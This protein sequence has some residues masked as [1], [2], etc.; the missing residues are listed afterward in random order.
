MSPGAQWNL[1]RVAGALLGVGVA[2]TLLVVS[3][4]GAA[5]APVPASVRFALAPVGE[6]EVTPAPPR[7]AL[8]ARGLRPG[9]PRASGYFELR[10]QTGE[11]LSVRLKAATDSSSLDGLLKVEVRAGDR[12]LTDTTLQGLGLHPPELRLASGE[13]ARLRLAAW[14]PADV[15][16][17]YEGARVEVTL[18]P[19]PRSVGVPR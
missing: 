18:V 1:V 15:L 9:G 17:G 4:P 8:V 10:N 7:P 19:A 3:R 14:L 12:L 11:E 13:R 6:L 2:A 16:S 5:V